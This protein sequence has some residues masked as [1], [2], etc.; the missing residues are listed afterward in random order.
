MGEKQASSYINTLKKRIRDK[1]RL[2]KQL[3]N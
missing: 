3:N 1:E 2:K